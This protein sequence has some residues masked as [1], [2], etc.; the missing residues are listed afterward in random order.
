MVNCS[1]T[2]EVSTFKTRKHIFLLISMNHSM[3]APKTFV[4]KLYIHCKGCER[5]LKRLLQNIPG[6][7]SIAIDAK[8]GT[9]TVSGTVDPQTVITTLGKV[10]KMAEL[11]LE[12]SPPTANNRNLQILPR[13]E[14]DD[15]VD[16]QHMVDH[17][18]QQLKGIKGLKHVELTYKVVK[19]TFKDDSS[20]GNERHAE[21]VGRDDVYRRR[22]SPSGRL[23]GGGDRGG[24]SG[25]PC[26]HGMNN[27]HDHLPCCQIDTS[28]CVE[29]SNAGVM[30][31]HE[32]NEYYW[33]QPA[34]Q[35]SPPPG[36]PLPW[37]RDSPSAPPLASIYDPIA[38]PPPPP[39]PPPMDYTYSSIFM[40]ENTNS[41]K[42]M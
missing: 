17:E 10:G 24:G 29:H 18:L 30:P 40:D 1:T 42:L 16:G 4:I 32:V 22:M 11:L 6:V 15:Q 20:C 3:V 5:K 9:M 39:P 19:L 38:P 7:D 14:V 33:L 34:W 2:K 12:Q 31:D 28:Y 23:G 21:V 36:P 8:Q 41:C 26:C 13:S 27:I 37:T 35:C 25:T